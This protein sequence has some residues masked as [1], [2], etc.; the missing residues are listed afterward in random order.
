MYLARG[1]WEQVTRPVDHS[2]GSG[3]LMNPADPSIFL[4]ELYVL[5]ELPR[6]G[7]GKIDRDRLHWQAAAGGAEL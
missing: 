1:P 2:P 3:S 7:S 5:A 6:T 4:S